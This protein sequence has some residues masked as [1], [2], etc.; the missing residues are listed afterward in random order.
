MLTSLFFTQDYCATSIFGGG[1]IC[2]QCAREFC[3]EC[4]DKIMHLSETC[5]TPE[6][7]KER[8]KARHE[9]NPKREDNR[10]MYCQGGKVEHYVRD[11]RP[12]TRFRMDELET[13]ISDM[14][15]ILIEN[16]MELSSTIVP[17]TDSSSP[18]TPIDR[19]DPSDPV[20]P[21]GVGTLP[22]HVFAA[23]GLTDEIFVPLW[24][25]GQ[26][27]VVTGL[28]DVLQ[29]K[30]TPDEF[31]RRY[32]SQICHVVD[33]DDNSQTPIAMNVEEFFS[34]FG[35]YEGR[36]TCLKLKVTNSFLHH[37]LIYELT[38]VRYSDRTGLRQACFPK[39]FLSFSKTSLKQ[40]PSQIIPAVMESSTSRPTTQR[41]RRPS[42]Q[43]SVPR[44]TMPL[45]RRSCPVEKVQRGFTWIWPTP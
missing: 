31:I 20:D 40:Y 6:E 4:R 10:L 24:A 26:T 18:P 32:G 11:L 28:L 12:V 17:E 37:L 22:F 27:V 15:T 14:G 13:T 5:S 38:E 25:K 21:S 43:I 16:K 7:V 39:S 44:C 34:Q 30:W 41:T 1:W 19:H 35:N 33:C 36:T 8:L 3:S 23:G 2:K 9:N 29:F 42:F 45:N